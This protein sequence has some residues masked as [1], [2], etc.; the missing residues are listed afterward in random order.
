MG[1]LIDTSVLIDVE[2]R[3]RD[4]ATPFG[5]VLASSLEQTLGSSEEIAISAIT[6]SELLHGVHRATPEHRTRREAFVEGVLA[7]VP[8]M[9]FDL[10]ASRIHARIWAELAAGGSDVGAHD[11]LIA[12]TAISLGWRIVTSNTRHFPR[13][14]GLSVVQAVVAA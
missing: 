8:T 9:P 5:Q 7:V 10:R 14:T 12:A 1:A 4:A 3:S 6:A 2:R 13:I 11:R